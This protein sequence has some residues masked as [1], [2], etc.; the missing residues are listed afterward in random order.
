MIGIN[1]AGAEFGSKRGVHGTN[2]I[3]PGAS[4]L[5]YFA[6]KG[7]DLV[8]LPFAWERMQPTL[9]GPLDP[10]ELARLT[11]FLD[12]AHKHGMSVILDLHNYGR[13]DGQTI[14]TAAVPTASFADF[15]NRLASVVGD[16]PAVHG[17]GLMNEPH[18]MGGAAVWPTAA[19][20]A[21][22]AIRQVDRDTTIVVAGDNWSNAEHWASSNAGLKIVDP[23]NNLMYEAHI[24]FDDANRGVYDKSYDQLA[25]D[26]NIGVR[27]LEPFLEW[28]AAN[29][30]RGFIG[31]FAVPSDDPRWLPVLDNFTAAVAR[32]GLPSAYWAG[33][34]W[35][36]AD[37]LAVQP[38][39][40]QDRPQM[41]VL[42]RYIDRPV[43]AHSLEAAD[44]PATLVGGRMADTL[45]GSA[46]KDVIFGLDGDDQIDGG[47]GDD[48]LSG[49][50][51]ADKLRGGDGNDVARGGSGNDLVEGG[52]GNDQLWGDDGDDTLGG[53][54]GNDTLQGGAGNDRLFGDDG[55]DTLG[56]QGGNDTL[57]GQAGND[58]LWGDEGDDT[59]LGGA[60][61][62]TLEGGTGN[63][64]LRGGA[65][66]DTFVFGRG[67]GTDRI[68]DFQP[69]TGDRIS[70][71]GQ[72]YQIVDTAQGLSLVLSG[73]GVVNIDNV[74]PAA[75]SGTW[76]V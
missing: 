24:Y 22:D 19:Q 33:G 69:W 34:P 37:R 75:W 74:E 54:G 5:A 20:A 68:A 35:W 59:L 10:A 49:G 65:D 70:L 36:G 72:G 27:R 48:T 64:T 53:Q 4:D 60:G 52:A 43:Q 50:S 55:D 12:A 76:L 62:D 51:G 26:P 56:G 41:A 25:V 21:V 1:L 58:R 40:G 61:R 47:A 2:Y 8:R 30:A 45:R 63:D 7:I 14:G 42:E 39:N 32:N 46:G 67:Q 44:G 17:Y 18:D 31:E 23:S 28:L 13:Y 73:G 15:W 16:H 6:G 3:Y 38:V 57:D 29:N 9:N 11:G 71:Q 66:A